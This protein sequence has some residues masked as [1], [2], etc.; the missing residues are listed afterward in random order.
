MQIRTRPLHEEM[1]NTKFDWS[2]LDLPLALFCS[3]EA[4]K[5]AA[6][7]MPFGS[8]IVVVVVVAVLVVI[9]SPARSNPSRVRFAPSLARSPLI[10]FGFGKGGRKETN[11][12][13]GTGPCSVG[14]EGG[15]TV[16]HYYS[17]DG[18]IART[19]VLP[20]SREGEGERP[21][22]ETISIHVVS[23]S[24]TRARTQRTKQLVVSPPPTPQANIVCTCARAR[25]LARPQRQPNRSE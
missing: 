21:S 24:S 4:S 18:S 5:G 19:P 6:K 14:G 3:E 13:L 20:P 1:T 22:H 9:L 16:T 17:L 11:A 12:A 2:A 25:L 8:I 15:G 7:G 23:S 10:E